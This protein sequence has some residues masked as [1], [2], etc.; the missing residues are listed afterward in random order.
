MLLDRLS[1][2][3]GSTTAEVTELVDD[4]VGEVSCDGWVDDITGVRTRNAE[5]PRG[6]LSEPAVGLFSGVDFS[7][8]SRP[9]PEISERMTEF[10]FGSDNG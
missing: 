5:A 1:F 6:M 7:V 8:F 2:S 3:I 4:V 10:I 9:A